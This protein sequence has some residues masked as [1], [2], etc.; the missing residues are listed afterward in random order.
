MSEAVVVVVLVECTVTIEKN[1]DNMDMKLIPK[2]L[3]CSNVGQISWLNAR[4]VATR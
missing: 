2:A 3:I 1:L 4:P